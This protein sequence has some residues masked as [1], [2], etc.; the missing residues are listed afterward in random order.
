MASTMRFDTWENP[1][2]TR[3]LNIAN[4]TPGLT[5]VIPTSV[6]IASG[7]GEVNSLGELSFT[8]ASSISLNGVFTSEY[9]N[10]KIL[11]RYTPA[12]GAVNVSWRTRTSG[13][14]YSGAGYNYTGYQSTSASLANVYTVGATGA[15]GVIGY[16]TVSS[17]VSMEITNPQ[18]TTVTNFTLASAGHNGSGNGSL[19]YSGNINV[20]NQFDGITFYT[21]ASTMIGEIQVYGYNG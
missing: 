14:D 12:S 8:G 1:T 19:H 10:Y 16:G 21:S 17:L 20:A 4:A 3:S 18:T 9:R 15:T 11:L 6:V 2:G 13:T 7:S 5:P